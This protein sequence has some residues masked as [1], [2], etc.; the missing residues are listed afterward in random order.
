MRLEDLTG[1]RFGRLT[2]VERAENAQ[3]QGARW[4]CLCDCGT[5]RAIYAAKLKTG[6]T[7]SCGCLSREMTA[8]RSTKH[9]HSRELSRRSEY[10]SW[11]GMIQRCANPRNKQWGDYGGRGI[12]VDQRWRSDF[13]KFLADMGPC[14][15]GLSIDRVH[16]DGPYVWWN[17]RWATPKEQSNNRRARRHRK[18]AS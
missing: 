14:P 7:K 2:V 5:E 11:S 16:N 1:L 8:A 9:G 17:C 18:A 10:R 6:H 15:A 13:R 4:L 12:S 3:C